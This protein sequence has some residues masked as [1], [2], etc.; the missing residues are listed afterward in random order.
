MRSELTHFATPFFSKFKHHFLVTL[1][2]SLSSLFLSSSFT[3]R[4][5]FCSWLKFFYFVLLAFL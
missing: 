3:E 5:L 4:L 1:F 2:F